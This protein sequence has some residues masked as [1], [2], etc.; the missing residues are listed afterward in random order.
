MSYFLMFWQKKM[1][2]EITN[3]LGDGSYD[4]GDWK[5]HVKIKSSNDARTSR[6]FLQHNGF[7]E[8]PVKI[9]CHACQDKKFFVT[10]LPSQQANE[11]HVQCELVKHS[12]SSIYQNHTFELQCVED[13]VESSTIV[14]LS[15]SKIQ[16]GSIFVHDKLGVMA[17]L[18]ETLHDEC[19]SQNTQNTT[20]SPSCLPTLTLITSW[21]TNSPPLLVK[22]KVHELEQLLNWFDF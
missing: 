19:F 12:V 2:H 13:V 17:T 21:P 15:S 11:K 7:K 18:V 16:A 3:A 9:S 5:L 14:P 8:F 1:I 4:S 20:V 10:I 6:V 22:Q